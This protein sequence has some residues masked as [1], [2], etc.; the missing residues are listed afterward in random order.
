MTD[1]Q[2]PLP[3][4]QH[5]EEDGG[6]EAHVVEGVGELGDEVDPDQAV[7]RPGP[8]EL[9]GQGVVNYGEDDEDDVDGGQ[10]DEEAVKEIVCLYL[11]QDEDGGHIPNYAKQANNK[12]KYGTQSG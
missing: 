4:Y 10:G 12:L 5:R 1:C 9:S 3:R 6:A 2:V 8:G 11:C 7:L